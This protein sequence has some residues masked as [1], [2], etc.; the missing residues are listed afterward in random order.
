MPLIDPRF[1]NGRQKRRRRM[2]SRV[3]GQC[4]RWWRDIFF[5]ERL[6]SIMIEEA[7]E[8]DYEPI[9]WT[10][11]EAA[12]LISIWKALRNRR[13]Q[14]QSLGCKNKNK[15]H[16]CLLAKQSQN[17]PPNGQLRAIRA[18]WPGENPGCVRT[19]HTI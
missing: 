9:V 4:F 7:D 15:T 13:K 2:F 19:L 8:P 10:L 14:M 5:N 3:Q 6:R 16:C 12:G 17:I 1:L 18:R 11:F